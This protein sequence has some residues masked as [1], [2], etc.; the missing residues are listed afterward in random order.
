MWT[1]ERGPFHIQFSGMRRRVGKYLVPDGLHFWIQ[2]R[3][4]H[5]WWCPPAIEF[6]SYDP[7]QF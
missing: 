5:L 1:L 2:N 7:D 6:D 3:G 4:V